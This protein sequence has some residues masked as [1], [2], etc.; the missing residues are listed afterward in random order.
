MKQKWYK[1]TKEFC[2]YKLQISNKTT[3][4]GATSNF[5]NRMSQHNINYKKQNLTF[6]AGIVDEFSSKEDC[7]L[8]EQYHIHNEETINTKTNQGLFYYKKIKTMKPF[9]DNEINI[10]P[11]IIDGD[12]L[13]NTYEFLTRMSKACKSSKDISIFKYILDGININNIVIIDNISKLAIEMD[14]SRQKLTD[15]LKLLEEVSLIKK[16]DRGIYMINPFIFV[17]KR[18][19]TNALREKAQTNW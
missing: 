9:S 5:K 6:I 19:R 1:Q 12:T 11:S 4:I 2:V 16:I 10:E 18:V 3:Y 7:S 15:M 17:G 14:I 13:I 8:M